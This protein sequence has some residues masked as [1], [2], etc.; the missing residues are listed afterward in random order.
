ML[1]CFFMCMFIVLIIYL[2]VSDGLVDGLELVGAELLAALEVGRLLGAE[3][4]G[5]L[6]VL[7]V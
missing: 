2:V 1:V 4:V 3:G 6:Q 5:L 7:F